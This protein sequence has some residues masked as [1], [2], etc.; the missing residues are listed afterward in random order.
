MPEPATA[1]GIALSILSDLASGILENKIET[2]A[3]KAW[4]RLYAKLDRA[5]SAGKLPASYHLDR[6]TARACLMAT[7]I[8]I[9]KVIDT[10]HGSLLNNVEHISRLDGEIF[11]RGEIL[12]ENA[13]NLTARSALQ[14]KLHELIVALDPQ[15]ASERW[16]RNREAF[17]RILGEAVLPIRVA[18]LDQSAGDIISHLHSQPLLL[19]D[20][21][22]SSLLSIREIRKK[23]IPELENAV[24]QQA[25]NFG[26]WP[27]NRREAVSKVLEEHL[28]GPGEFWVN[29][30]SLCY[31]AELRQDPNLYRMATFLR[32]EKFEDALAALDTNLDD[33]RLQA[34]SFFR[35]TRASHQ[36]LS[37]LAENA[38][39]ASEHAAKTAEIILAQARDQA[40]FNTSKV[41]YPP[42]IGSRDGLRSAFKPFYFAEEE[43]DF[44][45]RADVV[46]LLH[47]KLLS[48]DENS[49][50]F[51][52]AAICGD[53]GTGKSRLA[54]HILKTYSATWRLSGFVRRGFIE[55]VELNLNSL[56]QIN[57]PALFIVDYA[58]SIPE[59]TCRFIE[60]CALL[61]DAAPFPVRIVVLLRRQNDRFYDY[62]NEQRD[63]GA[64]ISS[65]AEL[66]QQNGY[67]TNSGALVLSALN[68]DETLLLMRTRMA[69]TEQEIMLSTLDARADSISDTRLLALLRS[70]DSRM[71]PLFALIVA[72]AYQ[73]SLIS[74]TPVPATKEEMRLALFGDYLEHQFNKK[75][76]HALGK[77]GALTDAD[78]EHIDRHITF[79]IL[80]TMCRG[81]TDEGWRRM[82]QE[83]S[84]SAAAKSVLPHCTSIRV[85]EDSDP[86]RFLDEEH[87]LSALTGSQR[88]DTSSDSYPILEPDLIGET[89][90]LL[91][92]G[93]RGKHFCLKGST[94]QRRARYLRDFAWLADPD[95]AAFFSVLVTQD[96]PEQAANLKWLLPDNTKPSTAGLKGKL[97]RSL[98]LATIEPLNHR[99]ATKADVDRFESLI[100][101]FKPEPS[102]PAEA[103]LDYAIGLTDLAEQLAFMINR[104]LTPQAAMYIAPIKDKLGKH[105]LA[106]GRAAANQTSI[107]Q[108][109]GADNSPQRESDAIFQLRCDQPAIDAAMR[110]LRRLYDEAVQ[111]VFSSNDFDLSYHYASV[112]KMALGSIFWNHR[113][114]PRRYGYNAVPLSEDDIA[115]RKRL[116][117]LC[118]SIVSTADPTEDSI[119]ISCGIL[120]SII[121][122]ED[123]ADESRGDGAFNALSKL[124][125]TG[126]LSRE[127]SF[128]NTQSFLSNHSCNKIISEL[129]KPNKQNREELIEL[130]NTNKSLYLH[131]INTPNLTENGRAKIA[132]AFLDT[133]GRIA[134]YYL[135]SNIPT[136]LYLEECFELFKQFLSRHGNTPICSTT[137]L[138]I[139]RLL[140]SCLQQGDDSAAVALREFSELADRSRFERRS[141][142]SN[143]THN[144]GYHINQLIQMPPAISSLVQKLVGMLVDQVGPRANRALADALLERLPN[145]SADPVLTATLSDLCV[146]CGSDV[147]DQEKRDNLNLAILV[148]K[149]LYGEA[150]ASFAALD[151]HWTTVNDEAIQAARTLVFNHLQVLIWWHGLQ[152][153]KIQ[154]WRQRLLDFISMPPPLDEAR[155]TPALRTQHQAAIETAATFARL[156]INAGHSPDDWLPAKEYQQ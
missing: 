133:A 74:D 26:N 139:S 31:A 52:W 127:Y 100:E 140:E 71:R 128:R 33:L 95:G 55:Q 32:L 155:K 30:L 72:D 29:C 121:Y 19:S 105:I 4:N 27:T 81:L 106:F 148:Q 113:N 59:A 103:L 102:N 118:N 60:R 7:Q 58:D 43:D 147:I 13:R 129:R 53:A 124:A 150:E 79:M 93:Q 15:E 91:A 88:I 76:K 136:R 8:S 89:L 84:L 44:T 117:D 49:P 83:P 37:V 68:E 6:G 152:H 144:L 77:D 130:R 17:V 12:R 18:H 36:N 10:G 66:S 40:V 125:K 109:F 24:V 65:Q 67:G 132:G 73:R 145:Q 46:R 94:A 2:S 14:K 63:G 114:D 62:I 11:E 75:W 146:N 61:A 138:F 137:L 35:D 96:Y 112:I 104:S 116:T 111:F 48:L 16:S 135:Q 149:L 57:G 9:Q 64:A 5:N 153:P 1:T 28:F 23:I 151:R 70:Y 120:S 143:A 51:K 78:R 99:A 142:N 86:S 141:F 41:F 108:Q 42:S 131:A 101:I 3:L 107:T 80:S 98:I 45:G 20:E 22:R 21:E 56:S 39:E 85:D 38:I 25:I 97:F 82:L 154:E 90:V 50:R 119:A 126:G 156:E 110:V 134:S 122:A 115:E 87:L 92:F 69:R 54:F 34:E 47:E 123:G